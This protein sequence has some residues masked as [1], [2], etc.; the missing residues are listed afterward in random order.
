METVMEES[1]AEVHN[2][3]KPWFKPVIL[4]AG[5][6]YNIVGQPKQD[7]FYGVGGRT[8]YYQWN[9]PNGR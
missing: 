4:F 1:R 2:H 9:E 7:K 3:P 6:Q 5:F 8:F